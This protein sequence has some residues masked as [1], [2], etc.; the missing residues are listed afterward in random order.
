MVTGLASL[1]TTEIQTTN[2]GPV[3]SCGDDPNT[4][5]DRCALL[6][7][8]WYATSQCQWVHKI[9]PDWNAGDNPGAHAYCPPQTGQP[10]QRAVA[11]EC[12]VFQQLSDFTTPVEIDCSPTSTNSPEF[13]PRLSAELMEYPPGGTQPPVDPSSLPNLTELIVPVTTILPVNALR[14]ATRL[15]MSSGAITCPNCRTLDNSSN[16]RS[17]GKNGPGSQR[18]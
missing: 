15:I 1:R 11:R 9:W 4:L 18:G 14:L 16:G 17:C 10:G 13:I 5:H 8:V 7:R 6:K 12:V 3:A 2:R